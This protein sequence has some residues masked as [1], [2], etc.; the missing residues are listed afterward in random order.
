MMADEEVFQL[1]LKMLDAHELDV[2]ANRESRPATAK[3][4]LLPVVTAT[5]QK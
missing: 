3:M 4:M 2:E 1:R 5:M